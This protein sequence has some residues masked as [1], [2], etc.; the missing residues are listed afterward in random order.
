MALNKID[1]PNANPDRVRQELADDGVL[2]EEYG[3]DMIAFRS[4]PRSAR[5][6]ATCWKR[7]CS[8][9]EFDQDPGKPGRQG[10]RH[11]D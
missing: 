3:D 2:G 9:A 8:P 1:R 4:R 10:D 5:G 7:S 11:G 6:S